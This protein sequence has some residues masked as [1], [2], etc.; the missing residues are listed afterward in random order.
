MSIEYGERVRR[1][2]V[3]PTAQTYEFG[4][5]LVKLASNET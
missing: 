4:G 1:I 3:Y 5:T 2:P